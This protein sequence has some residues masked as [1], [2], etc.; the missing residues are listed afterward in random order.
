[1]AGRVSGLAVFYATAG[2]VL[3]WSGFKG[4]TLAET[5]KAIT[6]GNAAALAQKGSEAVGSPTLSTGSTS[7]S[8]PPT[9]SGSSSAGAAL[10]SDLATG[11]A[12]PGVTTGVPAGVSAPAG[13]PAANKALGL[14]L[15]GTYGWAGSEWPYLESGWQE[16]S[17]WN[18]HAANDPGDPYNHAYG[19]PQANPGTKMASAGSGWK[20]DPATQIRWGLQYIKET[21]GSPSKVPGWTPNGP[22]AGYVGY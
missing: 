2:G 16:E 10:Q 17:G 3:L 21:Y 5:I 12:I 1:M 14:L 20:T 4:Q 8:A 11:T 22:G 19:I 6:S 7:T 15:A 18:Q 13:T 9:G